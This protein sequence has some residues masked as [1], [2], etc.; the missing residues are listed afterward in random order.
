MEKTKN[1]ILK[2]VCP[3]FHLFFYRNTVNRIIFIQPLHQADSTFIIERPR[4]RHADPIDGGTF[5]SDRHLLY[6]HGK[7][8]QN[9]LLI[10]L[11]IGR[12]M[13]DSALNGA[14]FIEYAGLN[15]CP[16]NI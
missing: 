13:A 11:R 3:L 16:A 6:D 1:C 5:P 15:L 8:I 12:K 10:R 4:K 7:M 9:R 14:V 2:K